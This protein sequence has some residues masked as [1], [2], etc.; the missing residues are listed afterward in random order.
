MSLESTLAE[1]AERRERFKEFR[2]EVDADL[3]R[4]R[5]ERLAAELAAIDN[6]IFQSA[7]EG[8]TLG[9]IKR[10]YG[11]KDH[12]T[13]ADKVRDHKPEIAAIQKTITQQLKGQPDWLI[14]NGNSIRVVDGEWTADFTWVIVDEGEFMFTTEEPL[15]D[16]TFTHKNTAV[17]V[18][19]GKTESESRHARAAAEF[20]RRQA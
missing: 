1:L 3:A 17:E 15:W 8:A 9:Q 16:P 13:I 18:L 6:L 14:Y 10:A 7:A 20:I 5:E 12:R 2:D 19:D 11:T 4:Q